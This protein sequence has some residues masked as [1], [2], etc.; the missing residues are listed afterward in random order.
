VS[1]RLTPGQFQRVKD[2]GEVRKSAG[3]VSR[4]RCSMTAVSRHGARR[5]AISSSPPVAVEP[6]FSGR[7]LCVGA[8]RSRRATPPD[9]LR[10]STAALAARCQ[11]ATPSWCRASRRAR[12]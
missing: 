5:A 11:P 6:P 8:R 10:C 4:L 7:A 9:A 3:V 1:G 2:D 12:G